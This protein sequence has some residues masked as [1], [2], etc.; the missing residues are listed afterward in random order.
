MLSLKVPI[1][2]GDKVAL[3]E[4]KTLTFRAKAHKS[5]GLWQDTH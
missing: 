4:T 3:N 5:F 2:K 1:S